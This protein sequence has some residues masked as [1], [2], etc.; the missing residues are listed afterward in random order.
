[1]ASLH[2]QSKTVQLIHADPISVNRATG[3]YSWRT[4]LESTP[5]TVNSY[6]TKVSANTGSASRELPQ[7]FVV[8]FQRRLWDSL[9]PSLS[10]PELFTH[11]SSIP[12]LAPVSAFPQP[13][14]ITPTAPTALLSLP[15]VYPQLLQLADPPNI[16]VPCASVTLMATRET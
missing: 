11:P 8:R 1:M 12:H 15:L 13:P 2:R 10:F 14:W 7:R 6:N 4:T 9:K 3:E 16:S 5:T